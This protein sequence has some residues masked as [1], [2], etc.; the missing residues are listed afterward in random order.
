MLFSIRYSEQTRFC[1]APFP[2][3][4]TAEHRRE[5]RNLLLDLVIIFIFEVAF[6]R[7][8]SILDLRQTWER[9]INLS[10]LSR[11]QSAD[12]VRVGTAQ[13]HGLDD[14]TFLF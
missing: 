1:R 2:R 10:R 12:K 9:Q 6:K 13:Q 5:S 7:G 11:E 14:F 3:A 4:S 8:R